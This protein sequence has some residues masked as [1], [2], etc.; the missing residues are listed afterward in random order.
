[1]ASIWFFGIIGFILV[2]VFYAGMNSNTLFYRGPMYGEKGPP[3]IDEGKVVGYII[4]TLGFSV[5]W[6]LSLPLIG[7]YMLGKRFN[8]GQ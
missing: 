2:R 1:M 4:I 6:P 5:T 8:K 7:V 3:R